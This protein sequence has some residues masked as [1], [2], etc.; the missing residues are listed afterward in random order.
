MTYHNLDITGVAN[1]S[2]QVRIVFAEGIRRGLA[3]GEHVSRR[4]QRLRQRTRTISV[5]NPVS[6]RESQSFIFFTD[7]F[8]MNTAPAE[9]PRRC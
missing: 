5:D 3:S 9:T 2:L 7:I 4:H 8:R 6:W 1:I